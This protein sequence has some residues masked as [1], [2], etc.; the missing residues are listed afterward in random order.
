[1]RSGVSKS[2]SVPMNEYIHVASSSGS[3]SGRVILRSVKL[4]RAPDI[5]AAS[6]SA[7][8]IRR[9]PATSIRNSVV[10]PRTLSTNIIP[11]RL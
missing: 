2:S 3:M 4:F 8:S 7:G 10:L 9:K 6:S 5:E 11:S 1:M